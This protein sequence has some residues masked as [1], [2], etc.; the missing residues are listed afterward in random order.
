MQLPFVNRYAETLDLFITVVSTAG[1]LS[2]PVAAQIM[3]AGKSELGRNAVAVLNRPRE[4]DGEL[5][6]EIVERLKRSRALSPLPPHVRDDIIRLARLRGEAETIVTRVL[7]QY[8][9]AHFGAPANKV[10]SLVD[11]MM[12][13][14]TIFI[15]VR[16]LP[17]AAEDLDSAIGIA[18]G[19]RVNVAWCV[20]DLVA[21]CHSV[22]RALGGRGVLL[23]LDEIGELADEDLSMRWRYPTVTAAEAV[24]IRA[25]RALRKALDKIHAAGGFMI[26]C[27]G[28]TKWLAMA[29]L[30]GPSSPLHPISLLLSPLSK[31]DVFEIM[32]DMPSMAVIT[33]SRDVHE[34]VARE[35]AARSGGIGRIIQRALF[36]IKGPTRAD[37]DAQIAS[38]ESTLC[39]PEVCTR[40]VPRAASDF[41]VSD[42]ALLSFVGMLVLHNCSFPQSATFNVRGENVLVTSLLTALGMHYAP[43]ET[44]GRVDAAGGAVAEGAGAGGAEGA[45]AEG[46]EGA[47]AVG[48]GAVG[49]DVDVVAEGVGGG[50]AGAEGAGA[51]G[52]G[53]EDA[54]C[55]SNDLVPVVGR[56]HMV[57][58]ERDIV[59]V[60]G[61][62]ALDLVRMMRML[63]GTS[64]GTPFEVVCIERMLGLASRRGERRRLGDLLPHLRGSNAASWTVGVLRVVIIPKIVGG[65]RSLTHGE[66]VRLLLDRSR[67]TSDAKVINKA[68]FNWVV[69]EWLVEDTLAVPLEASGSQDWFVRASEGLV[70]FSNKFLKGGLTIR[71]VEEELGKAPAVGTPFVLVSYSPRLHKYFEDLIGTGSA[72]VLTAAQPHRVSAAKLKGRQAVVVSPEHVDGLASLVT[73]VVASELRALSDGNADDLTVIAKLAK[74]TTAR[75]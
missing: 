66:R 39:D 61:A 28:R 4:T 59:K 17:N 47:G 71:L 2:L 50:G 44:V 18:I 57:A 20:N 38:F 40:I 73:P 7:R 74:L 25:M 46:A 42:P 58:L 67:W 1:E 26:Y 21:H 12:A 32:Q 11:G 13:A 35:V 27:T 15:S 23:V 43:V 75:S 60:T 52:A 29:A 49:V 19:R 37:V 69:R 65:A 22:T 5:E 33:A 30:V 10:R 36:R 72:C 3:G 51:E 9:E 63:G 6:Q 55:P 53:A 34:Y 68:D 31:R 41:D 8:M 64:R 16:M 54:G 14:E 24:E 56:W 62:F 48:A 70:G 45:G